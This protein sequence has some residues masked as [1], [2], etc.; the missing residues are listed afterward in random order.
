[1][2]VLRQPERDACGRSPET[3]RGVVTFARHPDRGFE[4]RASLWLP[5]PIEEIFTFFSDAG[6]LDTITPDHL[7]FQ[8]LTPRPIEMREGLVLDYRL[9]LR[10][11]P[12][13]WRSLISRWE[14][15]HRFV[16]E[17]LR[18]PY[19]TWIHE[20]TFEPCEGGTLCGDVVNYNMIGG[21]LAD[22]LLVRRDLRGIF[23][24]RCQKL[25]EI[26]GASDQSVGCM[27]DR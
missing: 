25:R 7:R 10:G 21:R 17:Q 12:L 11:I 13:R 9:R 23:R 3:E 24:H 20:H 4:L 1:M 22:S 14:P 27:N 6:N 19:R 18:G 26:L 8:I 2:S 16:D 5:R 15:P